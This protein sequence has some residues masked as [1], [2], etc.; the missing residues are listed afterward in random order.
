MN[1]LE[2]LERQKRV[3]Q[4]AMQTALIVKDLESKYQLSI[5][6]MKL[7]NMMTLT[8]EDMDRIRR[9]YELNSAVWCM[10]ELKMISESK[11]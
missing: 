11:N 6:L 5:E 1:N 8:E 4:E 2:E 10:A 3:V 9:K 7:S